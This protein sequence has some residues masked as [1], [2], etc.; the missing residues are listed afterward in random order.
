MFPVT[1]IGKWIAASFKQASRAA[2]PAKRPCAGMI[3][4]KKDD[5]SSFS[6]DTVDGELLSSA[7]TDPGRLHLVNI[8]P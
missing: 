5:G 7:S 6:L 2:R 4:A 3:S 8:P 1:T